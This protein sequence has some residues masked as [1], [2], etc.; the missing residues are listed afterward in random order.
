MLDCSQMLNVFAVLLL[1][2]YTTLEM[3]TIMANKI[4]GMQAGAVSILWSIFALSAIIIGIKKDIKG[5]R[6]A[7]LSLFLITSL[8]VFFS[9]LSTLSQVYRI[10]AFLI[11]GLIMLSGSFIYIKFQ[12]R[13][14]QIPEGEL[15]HE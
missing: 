13:F 14:K 3:N 5:L 2:L 12:D 4:P 15:H 6:Y 11:F 1:F 7:G 10:V 8:K 9:D